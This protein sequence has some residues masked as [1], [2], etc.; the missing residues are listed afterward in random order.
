MKNEKNSNTV[1]YDIRIYMECCEAILRLWMDNIITDG[2]Y[3]RI[4]DRL[5]S[6]W[7]MEGD[8]K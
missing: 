4:M 2:E 3:K 5:V 8:T 6:T 7:K 1:I